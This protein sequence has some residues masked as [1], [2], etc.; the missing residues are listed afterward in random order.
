MFFS[1]PAVASADAAVMPFTGGP[2][3]IRDRLLN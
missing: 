2:S 1:S 3:M